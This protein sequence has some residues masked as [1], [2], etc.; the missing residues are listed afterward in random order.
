MTG[1]PDSIRWTP[2]GPGAPARCGPWLAA[3]A[4][5]V[6]ACSSG[7]IAPDGQAPV[8][9]NVEHLPAAC[10]GAPTPPST[11][12][13]TGLYSD[14]IAKQLNPG[15]EAYT[16]AVPLWSDGADKDRW[17]RLPPGTTIDTS[18]PNEWVFPVG[19]KLWKQFV[20]DGRRVET[21]LWQKVRDGFWV[22]AVYAWNDDQTAATVSPGGDVPFGSGTYHIPTGDEC[23]KCHRGRTEH[24]LGFGQVELG[25]PGASGL[26]L[27][28]LIADGRLS[29]PP[30]SSARATG[31][32]GTGPGAPAMGWLPA[33]CGITCH[34]TN[35]N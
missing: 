33:N 22:H 14:I 2:P 3:A 30:A 19:T 25:L 24:I 17:I 34:N 31:T 11:L 13:C 26:T 5:L 21:R 15:V 9:T 32:D 8:G 6:A 29:P 12:D 28:R 10:A 4:V 20:K 27:E 18:K 35:S 1:R 7:P 16:P 23:E